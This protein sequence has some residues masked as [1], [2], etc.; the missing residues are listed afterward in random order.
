MAT[1]LEILTSALTARDEEIEGYQINI[2]NFVRA[3]AL[4]D[5]EHADN[6]AMMDFRQSLADLLAS[7]RTEQLKAK[8]IRRVIKDQLDEMS[9]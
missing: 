2:D 3:I 6:P 4:I 7:N 9:S 8:I 5:A 1:K